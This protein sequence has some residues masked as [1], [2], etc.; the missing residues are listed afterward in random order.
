[1]AESKV[2]K[3]RLLV[4]SSIA[5]MESIVHCRSPFPTQAGGSQSEVSLNRG[6]LSKKRDVRGNPEARFAVVMGIA[7]VK[8]GQHETACG[9]GYWESGKD[10]PAARRGIPRKTALFVT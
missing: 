7:K 4:V 2:A 9:K 3:T 5:R 8:S 10:E 1:M 6:T